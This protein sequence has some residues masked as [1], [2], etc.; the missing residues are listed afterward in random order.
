MKNIIYVFMSVLM[1]C[2]FYACNPQDNDNNKMGELGSISK[3]QVAYT[4]TM[5]TKSDNVFEF[6]NTS[7]SKVPHSMQWNLGNGVLSLDKTVVA[8]Y[9]FAG[10]YTV[11][12]GLYTADG[13]V[14]TKSEILKIEKNDYS[15]LNTKVYRALTG[16]IENTEGKVWVLDQYNNFAKEVADNT[17]TDVKGHYGLGERDKYSQG[18][19]SAAPNEKSTWGLYSHKFRFS[20]EGLKLKITNAEGKGY[21]RKVHAGGLIVLE[22]LGADVSFKYTGGDYTFSATDGEKPILTLS[23]NA[24]LSYYC[25]TQDYEIFYLTD[26]VFAARV[27]NPKEGHDWIFV[28]CREELNVQK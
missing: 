17:G 21:A 26:D 25:G 3:E 15:L 4:K 14:V 5:S 8:K 13:N 7:V 9:P 24:F 23:K 11:T 10:E 16:G 6:T 20:L 22:D 1:V 19:W 28:F 27:A 18:W 12:L 2:G